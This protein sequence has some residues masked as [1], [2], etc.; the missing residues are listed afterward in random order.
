[1]QCH[2]KK[3]VGLLLCF[4]PYLFVAL[5]SGCGPSPVE[6]DFS[7]KITATMA[8]ANPEHIRAEAL[9][10][11]ATARIKNAMNLSDIDCAP[12]PADI[13]SLP[14]FADEG[15]PKVMV[16]GLAGADK[17]KLKTMGGKII[18]WKNGVYFLLEN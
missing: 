18:P 8:A 1:M 3:S 2:C 15:G 13:S 14:I 12:V 7:K 6:K 9:D 16:W 11:L 5:I 4:V 10:M 17:G